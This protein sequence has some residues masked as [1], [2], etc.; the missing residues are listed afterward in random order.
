M[1]R[2]AGGRTTPCSTAT[3]SDSVNNV[4]ALAFG[5]LIVMLV[6]FG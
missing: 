6:V 2:R 3:G 5:L 4:L 1:R